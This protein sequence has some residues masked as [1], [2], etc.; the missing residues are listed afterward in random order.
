[1]TKKIIVKGSKIKLSKIN[2]EQYISLTDLA[3]NFGEANVLIASWLR[4]KDTLEYLGVWEKLHNLNFKPHEF[5]GFLNQAG[6]N[7]FN[8]SPQKWTVKTNSIS[9]FSKSGRYG[10]TFAHEDIA[11]HFGQWL[12]PEFSLYVAKEFKRF[13]KI[14]SQKASKKWQLN[15]ELS[16]LNYRIHTDAVDT[17]L[18]PPKTPNKIK[19]SWF[20]QEADL[21]NM[22]LFGKTAKQW[23]DKNPQQQGNIRDYATH[24]QLLV[25]ANL[26]VLNSQFIK[27]KLSKTKRLK[28][29][30][31]AAI[32]QITSLLNS[33]NKKLLE[34]EL[35]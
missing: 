10:G 33:K 32:S 26:E 29:L 18:I 17:H 7:R 24:K 5:V 9:I 4:R 27:E 30:N 19:W 12:S 35:N 15:R 34:I 11:I 16:K 2:G 31:Q 3:Q 20:T 6:T 22:A 21:L 1:M 25:L 23:R 14:E 28:K 8:I 13:K